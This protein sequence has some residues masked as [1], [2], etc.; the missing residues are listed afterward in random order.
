MTKWSH[1]APTHPCNPLIPAISGPDSCGVAISG[2]TLRALSRGLGAGGVFGR[3]GAAQAVKRAH[4]EN[5]TLKQVVV[6]MGWMNN[7]QGFDEAC[8]VEKTVRREVPSGSTSWYRGP[9]GL[10]DGR[11]G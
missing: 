8:A 11:L 2:E 6:S 3:L 5:K 7:E 4:T 1:D 10:Q 9:E